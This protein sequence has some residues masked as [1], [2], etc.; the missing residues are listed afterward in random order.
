MLPNACPKDE[1]I[2]RR[3]NRRRRKESKIISQVRALVVARDGEC[4]VEH[5]EDN[6]DDWHQDD[7]NTS[8]ECDG[9]A[10]W[11]HFGDKKRY[12]TRGMPPEER[13]TPEGSLMLCQKHHD[14][15]DCRRKPRLF[16]EALSDRGAQGPLLFVLGDE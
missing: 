14:M 16:I 8:D 15:Y 12:R 10:Q 1:P 3:K 6:P 11:A 2:K 9:P 4:R 5:W 7:V 13:H